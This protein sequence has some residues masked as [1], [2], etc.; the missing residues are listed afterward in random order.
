[1]VSCASDD[2]EGTAMGHVR[3]A[4]VQTRPTQFLDLTGRTVQEFRE[5]VPPFEAAFQAQMTC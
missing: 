5:L 2:T 4:D 3:F 1:M